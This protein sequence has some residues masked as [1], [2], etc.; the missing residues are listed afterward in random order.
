MANFILLT[1]G[2]GGDLQPFIQISLGLRR[3]GHEVTLITQT[4]FAD[5]VRRYGLDFAPLDT[6]EHVEQMKELQSHENRVELMRNGGNI[7]P[8]V[9]GICIDVFDSIKRRHLP[10]LTTLISHY[11]LGLVTQMTAEALGL[12]YVEV[13]PAPYFV[14]KMPVIEQT[15]TLE[16]DILNRYRAE[17]G[18][19]PVHDWRAWF[20]AYPCKIGLWP[21]WFAP[22]DPNWMVEVEPVGFVWNPEFETGGMPEEVR[23]FLGDGERPVLITHGTSKPFKSE[24][25]SASVE[26]CRML[27]RK[28]LLVTKF[29]ELVPANLPDNVKWFDYLPFASLLP[30]TDAIIHHGGIGT[31]NQSLAAGVPQLVLGYGYDRP[32]NGMR[33]QRL[34]VGGYLPPVRWRPD[35]IADALRRAMTPAVR[36]R[37]RE[38]GGGQRNAADPSAAACEV[39]MGTLGLASPAPPG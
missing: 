20:R 18:L 13:F 29:D 32:D 9:W 2:T 1:Q 26:A 12:P 34:G 27:G 22:N 35:L 24:F 31:L 36:E 17:M 38:L 5:D 30:Q 14:M 16:T 3:R 10:G 4:C 28:G 11:N 19:P 15:F 8:T 23:E 7:H 6:P 25:F 33:V 39:I 21:E 37:C